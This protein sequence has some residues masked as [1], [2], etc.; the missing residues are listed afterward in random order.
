MTKWLVVLRLLCGLLLFA[1][2]LSAHE[3]RPAYLEITEDERHAVEVAWK[4]PTL[5]EVV[6][7]L[8]PHL[9]AGW[10]EQPARVVSAA[11]NYRVSRW[12]IAPSS[13]ELVGQTVTIGGLERTGTDVLVRVT[14]A[15]GGSLTRVLHPLAPSFTI[16]RTTS[17]VAADATASR[18]GT[19]WVYLRLGTEHILIGIDHLLFI[20]ALSFLVRG[21]R[22]RLA[23]ISAFTAAHSLTLAAATLG[24]V[25]VQQLPVEAC[26][27]LSIAFVAREIVGASRGRGGL[28]ERSPWFVAFV[29]G[30]LH[31]FG[32]AGALQEIGLPARALVPALLFF[33]LGV[34]FGQV[35]F[36]SGLV[37]LAAVVH[38]FSRRLAPS[39][40]A[41]LNSS[42]A[43]LVPAYAIGATA[44]F[45]VAERVSRF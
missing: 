28:A 4:E 27:A 9:S 13:V 22:R 21:W 41:W 1:A 3:L 11:E 34:E 17:A 23:T 5:G 20:V 15:D 24:W 32:F 18:S 37:V 26:I 10:L 8:T 40:S 42:S 45:W 25:R 44:M 12:S 33:N 14:F 30:L 16:A 36:L 38:S 39:V 2:D 29:F 31:G 6:L 43:R 19:A 35:V 7:G